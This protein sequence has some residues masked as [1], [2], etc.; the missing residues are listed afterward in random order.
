MAVSV[1]LE[2]DGGLPVGEVGHSG[3]TLLTSVAL[4]L[5][6]R[7]VNIWTDMNVFVFLYL[8]LSLY[9]HCQLSERR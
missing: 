2:D 8:S 7:S 6:M 1:N 4:A 3:E 5:H 9:L